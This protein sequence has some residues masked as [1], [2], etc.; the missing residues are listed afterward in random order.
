MTEYMR[1]ILGMSINGNNPMRK[2][3]INGGVDVIWK[4][5]VT[6]NDYFIIYKIMG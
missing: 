5:K 3:L 1:T 2:E 4:R 6:Y